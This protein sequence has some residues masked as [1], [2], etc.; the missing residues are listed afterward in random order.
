VQNSSQTVTDLSFVCHLDHPEKRY[1]EL[2]RREDGDAK[3]PR[4][5]YWGVK[6]VD[7][8]D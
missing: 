3:V 7:E 1:P 2:R 5:E 4:C 8:T 6:T